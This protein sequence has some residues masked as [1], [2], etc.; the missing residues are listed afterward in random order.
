MAAPVQPGAARAF[1]QGWMQR[2][3]TLA[4]LVATV[5]AASSFV[6]NGHIIV[7]SSRWV[8]RVCGY[9]AEGA[10]LFAVLLISAC[11]VAP[12]FVELFISASL[13]Q[14]LVWLALI[15]LAL[16]PEVILCN[17]VVD[18]IGH[19][20]IASQRRRDPVA[21][22]WAVLFTVPTVLFFFLTAATLNTLA[23]TGGNVVQ[24][25]TTMLGLRCFTG[26]MYGLLQMVYAGV[27][28]LS[29]QIAVP[30]Q[31][32]PML[33]NIPPAPAP[34]GNGVDLAALMARIE[35]LSQQMENLKGEQRSEQ[36][37]T[38][39]AMLKL[40]DPDA[41]PDAPRD[42]FPAP[43]ER[44]QGAKSDAESDAS[45]NTKASRKQHESTRQPLQ[46]RRDPDA[47]GDASPL[48]LV[49]R[50]VARGN[51][52]GEAVKRAER[53]IKRHPQITPTELAKR[54]Q[55]SRSYASQLLAQHSA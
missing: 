6:F 36:Q 7:Y 32:A 17:A 4:G 28:R 50:K 23:T 27:G 31:V 46:K 37:A 44:E 35:A 51:T 12:K 1:W 16:I 3:H 11:S 38:E 13:M 48:Q 14:Y 53:I 40:C 55:I 25:S 47:V 29:M 10:L 41:S 42:A 5:G 22:S 2:H 18:A 54:A 15:V 20:I 9:V 49:N 8:I 21:W 45:V 34:A 39:K 24:A 19:W 30:Q 52:R 43:A 26:W 33:A